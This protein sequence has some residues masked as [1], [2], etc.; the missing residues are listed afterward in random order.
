MINREILLR[1]PGPTPIPAAIQKALSQ[2]MMGHRSGVFSDIFKNT[3]RRLR[4]IFGTS[5]EILILTGSG[6]SALE[7]AVVNITEQGDHV[8]VVVTGAFGERFAEICQTYGLNVHRLDCEWGRAC[9]PDVLRSFLKSLPPVTAVFMT[10]CETS[11]GVLNDIKELAGVVRECTDALV[12]VDAVSSAAGVPIYMDRWNLDIV[13]TGSQKAL[14]CPPG[15]AFAAVSDRAWQRIHQLPKKAFY[16]NLS[17]YQK[18]LEKGM[19]PYTP[20]ISLIYG[21]NEA[22]RLIEEEGLQ[23]VFDRHIV[24]K[25]MTRAAMRAA[26]LR[27]LT[28]DEEASP[29]VTA[30]AQTDNWD[31]E[32][33]R[34]SAREKFNLVLAG[35]QK[36]LKGQL[37]RFGHMGACTP[38]E[39]IQSLFLFE[40]ALKSVQWPVSTGVM[41]QAAEEVLI[42]DPSSFDQ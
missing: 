20:A 8:A 28:S 7:A 12:V 14:M 38:A 25:R 10:H 9:Q 29:T 41:V 42:N 17:T 11:T 37:V 15:L 3:S 19:S 24:L 18:Q 39:I 23:R 1:T 27:L 6:T 35:G 5:Q 4:P 2:P 32:T 22:L 30:V 16:L 40:M 34:K 21:L 33:F 26:G 31:T 13:V 36:K